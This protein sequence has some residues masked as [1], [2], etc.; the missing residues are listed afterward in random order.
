MKKIVVMTIVRMLISS[1]LYSQVKFDNLILENQQVIYER[2]FITDSLGSADIERLLTLNIPKTK[3]LKNFKKD[4][5]IITA[6]IEGTTIDYRNCGYNIFNA[7]PFLAHP[8][9]A[10]C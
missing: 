7:P 5:D 10:M 1:N 2:V 6:T 9:W 4:D 8:F 3:N